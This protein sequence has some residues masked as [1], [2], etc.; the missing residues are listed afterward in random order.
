MQKKI[1]ALAVAG[2]ASTAAFAQT[3]VTIY[4]VADAYVSYQNVNGGAASNVAGQAHGRDTVNVGSGGLTG[5]RLG[6]KGTEDLGNG[7]KAVFTLE[8]GLDLV[9]DSGIGANAVGA[10]SQSLR[11]GTAFA[12][13]QFVGLSGGFGTVSFGRQ[14]A[15]GYY[16]S[17]NDALLYSI[18]APKSVM[19][20]YLGG[21]IV[22]ASNA[23]WDNSINYVTNNIGGFSAQVIYQGGAQANELSTRESYG[24]GLNYAAGPVTVNYVYQNAKTLATTAGLTLGTTTYNTL[25]S[26]DAARIEEHYIGGSFDAGVVKLFASAQVLDQGDRYV[27]GQGNKSWGGNIGIQVPVGKGIIAGEYAYADKNSNTRYTTNQL[28]TAYANNNGALNSVNVTYLHLLSKRTTLYAGVTYTDIDGWNRTAATAAG[29]Q[30][31]TVAA[32]INHAF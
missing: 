30:T 17:A 27:A 31:T 22:G 28:G 9:N 11:A 23:R 32:G 4:G 10:T 3:N 26:A 20:A 18:L 8:Y 13:Q 21:T 19:Q 1:I 14:Y 15:P 25:T 5:S 2:L 24:V 12:R 16:A 7:L 6:F 29:G